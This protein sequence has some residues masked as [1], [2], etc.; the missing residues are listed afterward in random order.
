LS[1]TFSEVGFLKMEFYFVIATV[2]GTLC[3]FKKIIDKEQLF[4]NLKVLNILYCKGFE[5]KKVEIP[6]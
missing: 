5:C 1:K 6:R 2:T 3:L 4:N